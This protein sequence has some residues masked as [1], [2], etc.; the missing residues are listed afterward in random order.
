MS[1]E[2]PQSALRSS[3]EEAFKD[4]Y[5]GHFQQYNQARVN[6]T[7]IAT[8]T[9]VQN[10]QLFEALDGMVSKLAQIQN[11]QETQQ[12]SKPVAPSTHQRFMDERVDRLVQRFRG[13]VKEFWHP[14][15]N[16]L[17]LVT[18]AK[19]HPNIQWKLGD[20]LTLTIEQDVLD[21]EEAMVRNGLTTRGEDRGVREEVPE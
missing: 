9:H 18:S 17:V 15:R 14:K 7:A 8:L 16:A 21:I 19:M 13:A 6:E 4:F 2:A 3:F 1:M 20:R 11:T 12:P 10:L 5:L